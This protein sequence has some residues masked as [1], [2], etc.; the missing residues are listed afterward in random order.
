MAYYDIFLHLAYNDRWIFT[1]LGEIKDKSVTFGRCFSQLQRTGLCSPCRTQFNSHV[2]VF[3]RYFSAWFR[4]L[5]KLA[6][7]QFF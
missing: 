1:K 6:N 5:G 2:V 4:A 7:R 3:F